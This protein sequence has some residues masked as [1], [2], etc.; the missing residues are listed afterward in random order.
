MLALNAAVLEDVRA[1][2]HVEV[3]LAV[4]RDDR[5]L[6]EAA[7]KRGG[8]GVGGVMVVKMDL[9]A[10][11][12]TFACQKWFGAEKIF[13]APAPERRII[14]QLLE[15]RIGRNLGLTS[16]TGQVFPQPRQ[17][18]FDIFGQAG[19]FEIAL[20]KVPVDRSDV[21]DI[22]ARQTR[23]LEA[24]INRQI[25]QVPAIALQAR[26]ALLRNGGEQLAIAV[27]AGRGIVR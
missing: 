5:G 14:A 22:T 4:H 9:G 1:V 8:H 21:I 25:G 6:V 24:D 23:Q 11:P 13:K 15:N 27:E 10:G 17:A 19:A 18:A 2:M 3:A 16:A 20:R 7:V 12:E 26:D